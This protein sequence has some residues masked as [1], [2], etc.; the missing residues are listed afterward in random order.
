[1]IH[2]P[3]RCS[4]YDFAE[5]LQSEF[6]NNRSP[7]ETLENR[8]ADCPRLTVMVEKIP[9]AA[10]IDTGSQITCISQETFDYLFK[11]CNLNVLPVSNL[12]I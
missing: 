10:L 9:I 11:Y 2:G 6:V 7:S 3:T 4:P 8:I 5:D 1:M 12:V